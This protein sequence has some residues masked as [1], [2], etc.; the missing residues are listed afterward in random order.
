M[1]TVT[2]GMD[3]AQVAFD[4]CQAGEPAVGF[5]EVYFQTGYDRPRHPRAST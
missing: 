2:H 4:R 3:A 5:G 1:I